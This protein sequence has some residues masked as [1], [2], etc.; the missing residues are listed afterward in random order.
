MGIQAVQHF[1]DRA[2]L[3]VKAS[4]SQHIDRAKPM[5]RLC[6]DVE[7]SNHG[8]RPLS[9]EHIGIII[10]N[11]RKPEPNVRNMRT[12]ATLFDAHSAGQF[13]RLG[14]EE[15]QIFRYD[16]FPQKWAR[17][18][19]EQGKTARVFVRLTTGKEHFAKYYLIKPEAFPPETKT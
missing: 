9:I 5:A 14:E 16:F 19:Y 15:K 2:R 17:A 1:L 11:E 6:V 8:R 18:L 4:M 12:D 10:P 13:L 3:T 7:V